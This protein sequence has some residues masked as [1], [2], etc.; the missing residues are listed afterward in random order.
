MDVKFTYPE[1]T[2]TKDE[3]GKHKRKRTMYIDADGEIFMT[4]PCFDNVVY[5]SDGKCGDFYKQEI[6]FPVRKLP[7]GFTITIRQE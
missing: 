3:W 7:S 6:V 4:L 1:E 2:I 5:I